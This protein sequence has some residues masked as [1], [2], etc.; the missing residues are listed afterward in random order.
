MDLSS[1][2]VWTSNGFPKERFLS[3]AFTRIFKE[4]KH[5]S[6]NSR[7]DSLKLVQR[8]L[9]TAAL[10]IQQTFNSISATVWTKGTHRTAT[11]LPG[12]ELRP[13]DTPLLARGKADAA[14]HRLPLLVVQAQEK[15]APELSWATLQAG[16]AW[17]TLLATHKLTREPQ[18]PTCG[19][20]RLAGKHQ[21]LLCG[22][23]PFPAPLARSP[24][25]LEPSVWGST[26]CNLEIN[27]TKRT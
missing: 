21:Y 19:P 20:P 13:L 14:H 1:R 7:I 4:E 16:T 27:K 22:R 24:L 18:T 9:T 8:S 26:S 12:S 3:M 5:T 17:G 2:L 15:E 6:E 11:W 10:I 23:C 25:G